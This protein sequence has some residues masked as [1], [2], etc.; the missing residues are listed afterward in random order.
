MKLRMSILHIILKF[1][2][3]HRPSLCFVVKLPILQVIVKDK[4]WIVLI[5]AQVTSTNL[6]FTKYSHQCSSCDSSLCGEERREEAF[7]EETQ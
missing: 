1:V 2:T 6:R 7:A 5:I 3:K 4:I